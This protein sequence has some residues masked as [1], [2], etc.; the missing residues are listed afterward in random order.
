MILSCFTRE[1]CGTVVMNVD[2]VQ[3]M[4]V[5]ESPTTVFPRANTSSP[6]P[7][8]EQDLCLQVFQISAHPEALGL[9]KC[10]DFLE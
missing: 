3:M 7:F 6:L 5:I 1:C 9:V 2:S 4:N 8:L 10:L